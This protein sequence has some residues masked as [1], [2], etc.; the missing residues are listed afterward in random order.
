LP[1]AGRGGVRPFGGHG[2]EVEVHAELA[3]R[4]QELLEEIAVAGDADQQAQRELSLHDDLLDVVEDGVLLGEDAGEGGR[5]AR[6][7]GPG[8]GDEDAFDGSR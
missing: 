1:S 8:H 5:D 2:L 4:E 3:R 6:A 7:V